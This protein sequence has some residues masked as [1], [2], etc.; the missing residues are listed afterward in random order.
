MHNTHRSRFLDESP[1]RERVSRRAPS[2]ERMQVPV[3]VSP[4][5]SPILTFTSTTS[6]STSTR[7]STPELEGSEFLE[8]TLAESTYARR[9]ESS[10]LDTAQFDSKPWG[11]EQY[12]G[13][14]R[15]QT[16]GDAGIAKSQPGAH[17]SLTSTPQYIESSGVYKAPLT[18]EEQE[19][20][21]RIEREGRARKEAEKK[22]TEE[23]NALMDSF[24][25]E[26]TIPHVPKYQSSF[27]DRIVFSS[28]G[29]RV[30]VRE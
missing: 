3:A 23:D 16:G 29:G 28:S 25:F 18:A 19:E 10:V 5:V 21:E 22:Q 17:S 2:M 11:Y 13:L 20:R 8:P 14:Q 7:M 1:R 6:T 30:Q 26:P 15:K 12:M 4:Q 9:A 27:A 24:G